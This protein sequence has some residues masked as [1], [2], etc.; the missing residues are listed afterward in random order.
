ME[1]NKIKLNET[2]YHVS[3]MDDQQRVLAQRM[4]NLQAQQDDLVRQ[5][6][7]LDLLINHYNGGLIKSLE[8]GGENGESEAAEIENAAG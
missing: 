5:I 2:E 7:E 4:V 6:N 1:I 8:K 3:D